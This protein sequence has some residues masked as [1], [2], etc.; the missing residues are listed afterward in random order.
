MRPPRANEYRDAW[1]G[2]LGRARVGDQV[3]VGGWVN[4]RRDHGGLI[5]IDL[6]DRSGVVQLVFHPETAPDAHA[7]AERLRSEH[8]LT[9]AGEVVRREAGNVNPNLATGEIEVSVADAELLAESPTPP[10]PVDEDTP[11]DELLR[12]RH[13]VIDLRRAGMQRLIALRHSVIR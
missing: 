9:A 1:A 7:L 8:V 11:V 13:R 6:R 2:E 4:R 5:F 12:L 10:F 3:R